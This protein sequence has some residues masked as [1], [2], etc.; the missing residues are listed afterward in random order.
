MRWAKRL[1][2][3]AGWMA[4]ALTAMMVAEQKVPSAL[5][6]W[7][8]RYVG[9]QVCME[10]HHE[11]AR[12]WA[13]LPHSQWMLDAKLPAH[14][15]GC[16][17]CH[18]PGSLHVVAR[19]GYIVAWEKLSVAEQ[20]AICLQCHQTVTADQWHASPHGSRQMGKW[21]TVAGSKG[22]RFPACTDC[23]EVHLPVPRRWMLKTNSSSLCLR[24]HADITEKTRQGEHHPLDK[25]QCA[26]C[27]DA[28]DGTVGGMLKAEP[29]TLCDRCHQRSDI[30]PA[31][32]TA[33]FRKVHG[34]R[35]SEGDRRCAA[36]HGRDGCD[37][38]HGLP[39][40]H[41][42][43]F[44]THHTEATKGQ[45]QTCRNCHDQNFCAKCHADAPPVS[46]DAP[47]YA[48]AGH[49]KEFRQFGANAAAYC[50]TCHQPRQC[51]DCHRQKGIPLEV[52]R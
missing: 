31:D 40:P 20:N 52:R 6:R 48:S 35:C 24:C 32:H 14:W 25:T 33:E 22:R 10:C 27:H 38:C 1:P 4:L 18:G 47:D 34:K 49:A 5:R 19:R 9:S 3:V 37:R 44:A 15:Q 36:C 16:E 42:Q 13:S 39:M 26:A 46:H 30:L 43:G 41:P 51:D 45:P 50:V 12:V 21:E 2:L 17:A 7:N 11:V 23:H 29:L 8:A 28:H